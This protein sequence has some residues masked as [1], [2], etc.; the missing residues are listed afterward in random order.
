M[1]QQRH[2]HVWIGV[3]ALFL[4]LNV[5]RANGARRAYFVQIAWSPNADHLVVTSNRGAAFYTLTEGGFDEEWIVAGEMHSATFS[6]DGT[7]ILLGLGGFNQVKSGMVEIRSLDGRPQNEL[8]AHIIGVEHL[9]YTP[10]GQTLITVGSRERHYG[11][12]A[13]RRFDARTWIEDGQIDT[14]GLID[15]I[16]MSPSGETIAVQSPYS[17]AIRLFNAQFALQMRIHTSASLCAVSDDYLVTLGAGF[18]SIWEQRTLPEAHAVEIESWTAH[19]SNQ[20]V[21]CSLNAIAL[22]DGVHLTLRDPITGALIA[23]REMR[24]FDSVSL[25]ISPHSDH[26]AW[27]DRGGYLNVWDVVTDQINRIGVP[28]V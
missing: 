6:P 10:D 25:E 26:V 9:L 24:S 20:V 8:Y 1:K 23:K 21:G 19:S 18:W 28:I 13:P 11:D 2:I 15:S 7:Q 22:Y 16:V 4:L 3:A 12:R 27:I 17:N 14:T 5:T